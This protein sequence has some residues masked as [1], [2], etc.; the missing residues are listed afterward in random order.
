MSVEVRLL[1][2]PRITV[3]GRVHEP[4]ADRRSA[5]LYYLAHTG[6]W[7]PRDDL[8]YLFWADSE[9]QRARNS[10]RQLVHQLRSSPFAEGLHSDRTRLQ[11]EVESD[12]GAWRDHAARAGNDLCWPGELLAGRVVSV[13][14]AGA[15][16]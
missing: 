7:V 1:G 12:L 8:L 15:G 4:Q 10:L 11:W 6:G 9:E 13:L 2:K 5:M 3:A 16:G 14:E